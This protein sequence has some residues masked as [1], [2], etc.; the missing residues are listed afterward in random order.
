MFL[1]K[2]LSK[3]TFQYQTN[4]CNFKLSNVMIYLY[5]RIILLAIP[6][7]LTT[8]A[9]FDTLFRFHNRMNRSEPPEKMTGLFPTIQVYSDRTLQC[10]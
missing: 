4:L 10:C 6:S 8:Q 2:V 7:G 9:Q 3:A 1:V 5:F